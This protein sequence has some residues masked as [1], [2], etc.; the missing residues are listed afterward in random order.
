MNLH[1]A[2]SSQPQHFCFQIQYCSVYTLLLQ[3]ARTR[4]KKWKRVLVWYGYSLWSPKI[5]EVAGALT[6]DSFMTISFS[7]RGRSS[8]TAPN[9][10]TEILGCLISKFIPWLCSSDQSCHWLQLIVWMMTRFFPVVSGEIVFWKIRFPGNFK[11]YPTLVG[12]IT[13]PWTLFGG[14]PYST[15]LINWWY[16]DTTKL[17]F[18]FLSQIVIKMFVWGFGT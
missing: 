18:E 6:H 5:L 1:M 7:S 17:Y 3:P 8:L 16:L 11:F 10:L 14:G 15:A 4:D 2:G 9:C 12:I 13:Q